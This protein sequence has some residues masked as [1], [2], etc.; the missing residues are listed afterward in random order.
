MRPTL[1]QLEYIVTIH[2]LGSFGLAA[3]LLNVSQPSLSA[4][5][6]TVEADL[7]VRLFTRG[8][9]GASAT[10]KGLECV[11]RA[12]KILSDVENLR[13]AMTST[14]PFDGRLR[15]GVLPSIGPYLLPQVMRELHREQP[16]LRVI[17]REENTL[18]LDEGLRNGRFD[19]IISTPEDHPNAW[20][21]PLFVER[22]WVAVAVDHP[23]RARDAVEAADLSNLRLLTLDTG[24]R[25]SRIVYA[26]AAEAG[27][28]VSN[29]YEGTSLDS[30]L[31][32]AATGAGVAVIPDLFARRQAVHREEVVLRPLRMPDAHRTIALLFPDTNQPTASHGFL[33]DALRLAANS[34]GLESVGSSTDAAVPGR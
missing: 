17:V 6:A 9:N 16:A 20:Q 33:T 19:A 4:Q 32:M 15:L 5:V 26:L 31:L 13:S 34:L 18:S 3:D 11:N 22:L 23:L 24:H 7:G 1:R 14:L 30:I 28:I 12:R 25:L 29:D 10:A 2:Q 8:R 27:G 21:R